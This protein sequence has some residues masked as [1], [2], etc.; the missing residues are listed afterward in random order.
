[1]MVTPVMIMALV[2]ISVWRRGR[3]RILRLERTATDYRQNSHQ[4]KFKSHI[5]F[6]TWEMLVGYDC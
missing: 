5:A 3:V 6:V 2:T 4:K 1:M